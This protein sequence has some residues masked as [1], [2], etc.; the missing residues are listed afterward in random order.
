MAGR[1][2]ILLIR[3]GQSTWNASGRWQGHADPPLSPLGVAQARAAA[4][5]IGAVDAVVCS[6]LQRA[7]VTAELIADGVGVGPIVA[8]ARLRERHAGEWTGLTRAEIDERYPGYLADGRR[9]DGWEHD[10]EVHERVTAVFAEL[11][12]RYEGGEILAVSHGGVIRAL[13]RWCDVD[14]GLVPNL[15][16]R[17]FDITGSKFVAGERL[18]LVDHETIAA[19]VDL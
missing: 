13:E 19:Q 15:G 8:D 2:R 17:W 10:P 11:H 14:E 3:H 1:T 5:V 9:P 7:L 4:Q 6:D 16:G 18:V 12:R